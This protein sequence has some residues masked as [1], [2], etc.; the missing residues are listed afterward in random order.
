MSKDIP[1]C[2]AWEGKVPD[3]VDTRRGTIGNDLWGMEM[4]KIE[5]VLVKVSTSG[6]EIIG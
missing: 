2:Q 4:Q 1:T 3:K 5:V 6:R